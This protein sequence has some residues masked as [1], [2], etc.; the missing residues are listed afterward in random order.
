MADEVYARSL[1][2]YDDLTNIDYMMKNSFLVGVQ[3][4]LTP[5]MFKFIVSKF[6]S[7]L[8]DNF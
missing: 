2:L 3:R 1:L 4:A 6:N 5:E 7:Y 8:A